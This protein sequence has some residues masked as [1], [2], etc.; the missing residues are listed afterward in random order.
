MYDDS[1]SFDVYTSEHINILT[2]RVCAIPVR[3]LW[4]PGVDGVWFGSACCG[5]ARPALDSRLHLLVQTVLGSRNR[6]TG[7]VSMYWSACIQ[8]Q[9]T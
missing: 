6:Q 5:R 1:Y 2:A 3:L 4:R 7:L 8:K 9:E